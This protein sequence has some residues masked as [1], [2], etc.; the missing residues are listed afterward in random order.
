MGYEYIDHGKAAPFV[1][2]S[3]AFPKKKA[4][5]L[6]DMVDV[7]LS[8]AQQAIAKALS[9]NDWFALECAVKEGRT[10]SAPD[11]D[12]SEDERLRRWSTQFHALHETLNLRLPDPEFVVAE[13]A[14]TCSKATAKKRLA[15]IGPWGAFQEAP[16]EIAP[17]IWLGQCAKF[18]CYRLSPERLASMPA[19]WRLDTDGWY[20]CD[21]HAWRVEL[22]FPDAFDSDTLEQAT[23]MLAEF[24]P[25]LYELEYSKWPEHEAVYI[26]TLASRASVARHRP[27]AWFALSVF[28]EWS[29]SD[30][31]QKQDRTIVSAIRGRDLLRLIESKGVWSELGG[32]EVGW[33]ATTIAQVRKRCQTPLPGL[34]QHNAVDTTC[35]TGLLAYPHQP[36]CALPFKRQ[37]FDADELSL[38]SC[39]S[40]EPLVKE[41][42]EGVPAPLN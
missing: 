27:E 24:Q 40:Y 30:D 5:E 10:P 2:A 12:V 19:H 33:F 31:M 8:L 29:L 21:D 15:D 26:P 38:I 3:M 42:A 41:I 18:Q 35:L 23:E 25:F 6:K 22:S 36:A 4:K 16:K 28:P 32:T 11:E 39:A 17:G 13:L 7:P 9:W 20:M 14:L 37:P 34:E 1:P